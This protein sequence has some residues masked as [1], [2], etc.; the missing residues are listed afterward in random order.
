MEECCLLACFPWFARPSFLQNPGSFQGN[1]Q[2]M[3]ARPHGGI[4]SVEAS[5]LS[6][7]S[8]LCQ[9][10][11]QNQT[12]LSPTPRLMKTPDN[13]CLRSFA[14]TCM[15]FLI[16]NIPQVH[17]ENGCLLPHLFQQWEHFAQQVGIVD[18]I[19][20]SLARMLLFIFLHSILYNVFQTYESQPAGRNFQSSSS[21]ISLYL[22]TMVTGVLSFSL[23][24]NQVEW[25]NEVLKDSGVPLKN[26]S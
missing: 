18:N 15:N 8:N 5:I 1:H 19:I 4:S 2:K 22:I 16:W 14:I 26:S 17:S 24:H 9:V 20:Y 7:F 3:P 10:D 13:V 25:Q 21:F 11:T 6:D 23:E 12:V